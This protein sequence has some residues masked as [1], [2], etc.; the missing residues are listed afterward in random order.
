MTPAPANALDII[1]S[2]LDGG[3]EGE[4]MSN[5]RWQD[6]KIQ[7]RS[8]VSRPFYFIRPFVPTVTAEG[9]IRKQKSIALGF[10]DELSKRKAESKKQEIMATVNQGRFMLQSQVPFKSILE[11][12]IEI[13]LP[14]LGAATRA[15]YLSHIENHIEPAFGKL[16]MC[17]IDRP[18]V[19]AWLNYLAQPLS[20]G[21]KTE[22]LGWWARQDSRNVLSAIFAKAAEWKLWGGENPCVRADV[23]RKR[24]CREKKIPDAGQLNTFLDALPATAICTAAEARLM[25]LTAV[26]AGVRVSEVL[27]LQPRDIDAQAQTI[28]VRRRWHRG[29]VDEPKTAN[30][31]RVRQVGTLAADLLKQGA[32]KRAD[33][34]LFARGDGNPPDDR[35]LQQHVFRPAAEAAGIYHP[36]FGMHTFRRLNIS[37]RQEVGATPFEAMKAA[38]HAKP[39]TTWE[40]TITDAQRERE[41]VTRMLERLTATGTPAQDKST[42]AIMAQHAGGTVQ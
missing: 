24:E 11:R 16:R 30:S 5:Q 19:E 8:D 21:A 17:D 32:G 9:I 42:A 20:D 23:G 38:G 14:Q 2:I 34:F 40:Y 41:H 15:K 7:I 39:S 31:K 29:D 28:E 13:R 26:A 3:Q 37:W 36:G 4:F 18:T 27:G 22:R 25:V 6:P 35:D 33:E 1:R 12:F 10:C